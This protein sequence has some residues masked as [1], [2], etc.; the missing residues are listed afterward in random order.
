M[1]DP[2]FIVIWPVEHGFMMERFADAGTTAGDTW[3]QTEQ[4][5]LDQAA[6][7][8]GERLG[9]WI[10]VSQGTRELSDV[11]VQLQ[12]PDIGQR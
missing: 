2:T 10:D 8:Y 9:E 4:D 7:E 1:L 12:S 11:L 6:W 3:H 5:A